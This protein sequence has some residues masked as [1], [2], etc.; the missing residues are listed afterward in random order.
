MEQTVEGWRQLI[1][2][3]SKSGKSASSFCREHGINDNRFFYWRKRL[4]GLAPKGEGKF[5]R[6]REA[7]QV[8]L[9]LE[10]GIKVRCEVESLK[11]VVDVLCA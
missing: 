5:V 7:K 2:A 9:E 6:L 4:N 8:E 10:S 11:A 3:Q 1:T